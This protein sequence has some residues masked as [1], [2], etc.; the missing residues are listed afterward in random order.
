MND[1]QL[2]YPDG[3]SIWFKDKY[4]GKLWSGILR[5]N[6]SDATE[7]I[8]CHDNPMYNGLPTDDNFRKGYKY[9]WCISVY[10]DLTLHIAGGEIITDNNILLESYFTL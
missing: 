4:D 1:I 2:K 3:M 9:S 10:N 7:I 8:L 6:P 5:H